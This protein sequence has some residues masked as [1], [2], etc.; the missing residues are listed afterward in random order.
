MSKFKLKLPHYLQIG[1]GLAVLIITWVVQQQ[2]AGQLALPAATITAL[3][4][5]KTVLGVLSP[6]ASPTANVKAAVAAGDAI[7]LEPMKKALST[8]EDS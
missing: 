3:V 8:H 7:S 5:A 2:S 4:L 6:S 1:I